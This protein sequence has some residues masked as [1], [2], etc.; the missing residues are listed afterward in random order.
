MPWKPELQPESG[1]P[2]ERLA[3]WVTSK[4]NKA[5]ARSMV[6]RM[7]ALLFN[8]PLISPVDDIPLE[9]PFPAGMEV[10]KDA[11]DLGMFFPVPPA[12]D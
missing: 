2:R 10:L 12:A 5:F 1:A 11:P 6:N 3:A 9:G 7:W 8:R 4:E